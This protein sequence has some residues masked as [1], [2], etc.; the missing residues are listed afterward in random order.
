MRFPPPPADD[1]V[2]DH[3]SQRHVQLSP[4]SP[5]SLIESSR[6]RHGPDDVEAGFDTILRDEERD[7][8]TGVPEEERCEC[9]RMDGMVER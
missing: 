5:S 4:S 6:H 8:A 2:Y 7:Y 1:V 3:I 9:C